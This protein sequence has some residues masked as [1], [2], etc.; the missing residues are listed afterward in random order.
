MEIRGYLWIHLKG[1]ASDTS[2]IRRPHLPF[3]G[4]YKS[5]TLFK[6][7]KFFHIKINTLN[8]LSTKNIPN[9]F[10]FPP[11][12]Q[13]YSII[14]CHSRP[15]LFYS[16]VHCLLQK[17]L[18]FFCFVLCVMQQRK[19]FPFSFTLAACLYALP[20][21]EAKEKKNCEYFSYKFRF[22]FPVVLQM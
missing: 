14:I 6:S 4:H 9:Q 20:M 18:F 11:L 15:K 16:L 10:F 21:K 17:L 19:L 7:S 22:F 1:V 8:P 2:W 5:S 3:H 13:F 12:P